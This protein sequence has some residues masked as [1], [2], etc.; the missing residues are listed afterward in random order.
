MF[1]HHIAYHH[2]ASSHWLAHTVISAVIHG[3]IYGAIFHLFRGMPLME[4]LSIA[5]IGVILAGIGY[6]WWSK[7]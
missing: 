7:R 5:V 6:M 2:S 1:H 3:L 4:V